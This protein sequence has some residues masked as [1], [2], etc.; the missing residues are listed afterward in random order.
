MDRHEILFAEGLRAESFNPGPEAWK[1]LAPATRAQLLA[2]CPR[3]ASGPFDM[4][5]PVLGPNAWRRKAGLAP[6]R[7]GSPDMD[8]LTDETGAL[9]T[10][11]A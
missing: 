6:L 8:M 11:R 1:T 9:R 7:P 3:L 5:R 2:L 4:A 10:M